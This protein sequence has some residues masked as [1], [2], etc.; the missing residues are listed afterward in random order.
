M[1]LSHYRVAG[2]EDG[3]LIFISFFSRRL[4]VNLCLLGLVFASIP[5]AGNYILIR[6]STA[7][8]AAALAFIFLALGVCLLGYSSKTVI[9]PESRAVTV[10]ELFATLTIRTVEWNLDEFPELSPFPIQKSGEGAGHSYIITLKGERDWL[11]LV[12]IPD[13]Q[14]ALRVSEELKS[15]LRLN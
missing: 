13:Y 8:F 1:R 2:T 12:E 4:S 15:T 11:P 14:D 3:K 5:V 10:K 7:A 9:C 6:S